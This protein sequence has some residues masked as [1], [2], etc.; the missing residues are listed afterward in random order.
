MNAFMKEGAVMG[1]RIVEELERRHVHR[2]LG[3]KVVG[4]V[5]AIDSVDPEVGVEGLGVGEA[6][7]LGQD[8]DIGAV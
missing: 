2:I 1:C 5:A 7:G 8:G 6:L 3:R 4:L